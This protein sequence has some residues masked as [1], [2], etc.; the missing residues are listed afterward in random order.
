MNNKNRTGIAG[1]VFLIGLGFLALT[2]TWWPGILIV[3]GLAA[4]ADRMFVGNYLQGLLALAFFVGVSIFSTLQVQWHILGPFIF[5]SL[6]L[7]VLV[8]AFS[9][10][11]ARQ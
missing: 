3:I 10:S 6:G 2:G 7:I 1:G 11:H 8:K 5:I 4:C 9:T